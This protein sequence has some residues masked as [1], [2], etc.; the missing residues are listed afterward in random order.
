MKNS[1]LKLAV[2]TLAT[3]L[4]SSACA[5]LNPGD[6]DKTYTPDFD[7]NIMAMAIQDDGKHVYA[8]AFKKVGGRSVCGLVRLNGDGTP[9]ATFNAGGTGFDNIA[10][11]MGVTAD[12]KFIVAG[13]FTKYNGEPVG[14]LVRINADG[15]LD[16]TFNGSNAFTL[17]GSQ[18]TDEVQL[19]HIAVMP[20]GRFYVAGGFNRVNGNHAPLI[21]R[22]SADGEYDA[23]F[24]PTDKEIHLKSSPY[25]D[26]FFMDNDGAIYL[27]G[28]FSAYGGKFSNKRMVRIT[29]EGKL[30][31]NFHQP[32]FDGF[33]KSISPYGA[34]GLLVG[35]DFLEVN[36]GAR[37]LTCVINKDG[38]LRDDYNSLQYPFTQN[39]EDE[40]LA[41]FASREAGD[42]VIVAGG[43]VSVMSNAFVYVL[44]KDGSKMSDA[45]NFGGGPN[46]IVTYMNVDGRNGF[47]YLSGFFTAFD[48]FNTTYFVRVAVPKEEDTAICGAK[49]GGD[50]FVA[51]YNDGTWSVECGE[52]L[53]ELRVT[54]ITGRE[55]M[56]K[57]APQGTSA[58]MPVTDGIYIVTAK[59]VSG[60]A[61][62]VK[63][64][65]RN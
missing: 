39:P 19:Q 51:R 57:R 2:I 46:A 17:E 24:L 11:A 8:G 10:S 28:A 58:R 45:F 13:S 21:A 36:A 30:D 25:V 49:G 16:R 27:G 34:D 53:A 64:A 43:D 65:V 31:D 6:V 18:F 38:S 61:Y 7:S 60:K 26:G 15:T 50:S 20:D 41:V 32:G 4:S 63:K 5:Q 33:V 47:A 12:G 29:P 44:S 1:T 35:G 9:D 14:Q 23:S 56:V 55:I 52:R 37:F 3:M 62:T 22:F 48:G 54:D 40:S 59:G 42:N